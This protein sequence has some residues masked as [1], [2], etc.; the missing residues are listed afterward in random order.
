M[1]LKVAYRNLLLNIVIL[2][3]EQPT[4]EIWN[5]LQFMQLHPDCA[6]ATMSASQ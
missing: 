1:P 5:N 2:D 3:N 4:W 6:K